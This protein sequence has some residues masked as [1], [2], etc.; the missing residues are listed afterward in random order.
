[1]AVIE[2]G[3]ATT[4]DR[5]RDWALDVGG[6]GTTCPVPAE[7]MDTLLLDC[8]QT[9]HA[10]IWDHDKYKAKWSFTIAIDDYFVDDGSGSPEITT[11][12]FSPMFKVL[13]KIQR[14]RD[15]KE[16]YNSES[17][18]KIPMAGLDT[19]IESVA[20]PARLEWFTWGDEFI[21]TPPSTN[22]EIYDV[23]GYRILDRSIWTYSAPTTTW[24]SVD[25][26]PEYIESYQK[27]VLGFLLT[28]T[29][30]HESA[31]KWLQATSDGIASE[32]RLNGGNVINRAPLEESEPLRMGGTPHKKHVMRAPYYLPD[33]V[34]P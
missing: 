17:Y 6:W 19:P 31:R 16:L 12:I 2:P 29:N 34:T 15:H 13:N 4:Y 33:L 27:C 24:Q 5:I 14:R 32:L 7:I 21:V 18:P 3:G 23:T 25:L 30:D 8:L 10:E 26:P 22:I 1:M 20:E 11:N 9:I 28:A